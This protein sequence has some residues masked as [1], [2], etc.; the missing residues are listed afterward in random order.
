MGH[1]TKESWVVNPHFSPH[2]MSTWFYML[3]VLSSTFK[4]HRIE[5][6]SAEEEL[7]QEGKQRENVINICFENVETPCIKMVDARLKANQKL[8]RLTCCVLTLFVNM[9]SFENFRSICSTNCRLVKIQSLIPRLNRNVGSYFICFSI[10]HT[11]ASI[12][13]QLKFFIWMPKYYWYNARENSY[14]E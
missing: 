3:F 9:V 5:S 11:P 13:R 2:I 7:F 6:Y 4:E 8:W 12:R 1:Q 10:P 14:D